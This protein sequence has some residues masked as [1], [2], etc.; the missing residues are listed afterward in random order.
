MRNLIIK[1]G[2]KVLALYCLWLLLFK[3]LGLISPT[4]DLF[5]NKFYYLI[6][7]NIV[8]T[9]K[10]VIE[11]TSDI[12]VSINKDTMRFNGFRGLTINDE[13]LGVKLISIFVILIIA[14]P[15]ASIKNKLW[16]IPMGITI[17]HIFNIFRAIVLSY[18]II[19]SDYFDFM[20]QFVFRV[21]LYVATFSL[22]FIWVKYFV[23]QEYVKNQ[24]NRT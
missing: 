3:G 19:Y 22:W 2:I 16:Y 1:T 21:I 7:N 17:L 9:T 5:I 14:I 10:Y 15:G 11:G 8:H 23:D 6:L 20:H 4:Y 24:F 18:T 12:V 13:C